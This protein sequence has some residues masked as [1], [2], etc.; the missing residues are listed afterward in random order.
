[1]NPVY[2]KYCQDFNVILKG[3]KRR[4]HLR[5]LDLFSGIGSGTVVL[6]KMKIPLGTVVHVEHDPVA[7]EVS[8]F[9]HKNDGIHHYYVERFEEIYGENEDADADL[10]TRAIQHYGP[11]DLVLA[12][13]PC[14]NYAQI[15]AYKSKEKKSAKYLLKVGL[16]IKK[17]NAIQKNSFGAT[18]DV[19]FL[20]ENVVFHEDLDEI[21][22]HYGV[23]NGSGLQPIQLDAKDFSPVKRNRFYWSNVSKIVMIAY[24]S[25]DL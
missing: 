15:N 10:L 4:K 24:H 8:R 12:A 13:A 25:H 11:F 21:N 20:S 19:L 18:Q 17:I 2:L 9:N 22:K 7:L 5:V 1:M 6:K 14:Q 3:D 16:L 23:V